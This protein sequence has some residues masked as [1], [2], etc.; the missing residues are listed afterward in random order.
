MQDVLVLRS[1]MCWLQAYDSA[2]ADKR[3]TS[4]KTWDKAQVW[5]CASVC[6]LSVWL[7]S[8]PGSHPVMAPL[9]CVRI[10]P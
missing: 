1:V 6:M 4:Q 3:T 2:T 10:G 8:M 5:F 9:A 7:L